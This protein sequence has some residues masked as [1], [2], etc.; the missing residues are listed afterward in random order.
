M[1]AHK[2][3]FFFAKTEQNEQINSF[4]SG[5]MFKSIKLLTVIVFS[6]KTAS[7]WLGITGGSLVILMLDTDLLISYP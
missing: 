6:L 3:G 1:Q 7:Q 2:L 5:K 4:I